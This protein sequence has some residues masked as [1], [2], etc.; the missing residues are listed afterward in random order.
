[1]ASLGALTTPVRGFLAI[2]D[3]GRRFQWTLQWSMRMA[4]W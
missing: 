3:M 1:M 2:L 4:M